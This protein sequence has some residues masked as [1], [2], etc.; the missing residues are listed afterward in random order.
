MSTSQPH[1]VQP[2]ISET[3]S[4]GCG[5]GSG[6]DVFT[7][8][9]PREYGTEGNNSGEEREYSR[10]NLEASRNHT[11]CSRGGHRSAGHHQYS[12]HTHR[13]QPQVTYTMAPQYFPT[14]DNEHHHGSSII[15]CCFPD[16]FPYHWV[17]GI[18]C[19]L[20]FVLLVILLL[21]LW[22]GSSLPCSSHIWKKTFNFYSP[23]GSWL[24]HVTQ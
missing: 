9:P 16:H 17:G 21:R 12:H 1:N 15:A 11:N 4:G 7:T 14:H 13:Y 23:H 2:P 19:L 6:H 20:F 5:S 18:C 3:G 8:N 24:F 10:A 22:K